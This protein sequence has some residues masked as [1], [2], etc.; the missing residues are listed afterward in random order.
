MGERQDGPAGQTGGPEST[1]SADSSE[2]VGSAS[3][4]GHITLLFTVQADSPEPLQQG[5]RGA[6]LCIDSDQPVCEVRVKAT[7]GEGSVVATGDFADGRLHSTVIEE[8]ALLIPEMADYD[9]SFEQTCS[10]PT[11]QGF[12]LSAAGALSAA[13]AAQRAL[14][15]DEEDSR[16]RSFH[17]AHLVERRLSGG[18]GDVAALWAGGVDLRREPG[19]PNLGETSGLGGPGEV[20]TWHEDVSMVLA[21]REKAARHTSSYIDDPEWKQRIT[22]SA[23]VLLPALMAGDWDSS[24]WGEL[25]TAATEFAVS[26]GLSTDANRSEL[27]ERAEKSCSGHQV[28]CHLCMLGESVVILPP[29]N[30]PMSEAEITEVSSRLRQQG[31]HCAVATLSSDSLR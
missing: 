24:R 14:R 23:E 17:V 30:T 19:C 31:L 20:E 8:L 6:G 15:L 10:L 29:L 4:S 22:Q 2:L 16:A 28:T 7:P 12:G 27:L 18:L 3:A 1:V 26:S 21:W 13:M 25:L 11:Q 9:W 5:S